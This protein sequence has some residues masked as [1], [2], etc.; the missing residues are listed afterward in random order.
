MDP[1]EGYYTSIATATEAPGEGHIAEMESHTFL[2]LLEFHKFT[3][4]GGPNSP[5]ACAEWPGIQI[6]QAILSPLDSKGL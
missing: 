6:P 3:N 2:Y 4:I 1:P 5:Y